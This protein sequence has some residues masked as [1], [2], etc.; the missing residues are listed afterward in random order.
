MVYLSIDAVDN[1][2]ATCRS[3]DPAHHYIGHSGYF[4]GALA[5][6]EIAGS[7]GANP[8]SVRLGMLTMNSGALGPHYAGTETRPVNCAVRYLVKA[9]N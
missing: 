6:Y 1:G 5:S 2:I 7:S 3:S 8:G 4:S 9:K